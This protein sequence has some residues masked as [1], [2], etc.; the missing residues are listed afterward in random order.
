MKGIRRHHDRLRRELRLN[1]DPAKQNADTTIEHL[2]T[3]HKEITKLSDYLNDTIDKSNARTL[4]DGTLLPEL[5]EL[6]KHRC[7]QFEGLSEKTAV[8]HMGTALQGDSQEAIETALHRLHLYNEKFSVSYKAVIQERNQEWSLALF[9]KR[10]LKCEVVYRYGDMSIDV[11][12]IAY[13]DGQIWTVMGNGAISTVKEHFDG[14]VTHIRHFC[15]HDAFR[16]YRI[17]KVVPFCQNRNIAIS[18]GKLLVINNDGFIMYVL[19]NHAYHDVCVYA[20]FVYGLIIKR[21]LFNS[22]IVKSHIK[23]YQ[24]QQQTWQCSRTISLD[25]EITSLS[26]HGT[27]ATFSLTTN[28]TKNDTTL[29][30]YDLVSDLK[31]VARKSIYPQRCVLG[32]TCG[33]V[34]YSTLCRSSEGGYGLN[35]LFRDGSDKEV[36][37]QDLPVFGETVHATVNEEGQL[38]VQSGKVL[39]RITQT[40][41]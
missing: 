15:V 35:V 13:I 40:K 31:S 8:P 28:Q 22:A 33:H 4:L 20:Q 41:N 1:T 21:N 19:D 3:E 12:D 16:T 2:D 14:T 5:M 7:A 30:Y 25:G 29:Y 6:T 9:L 27:K 18:E 34:L 32:D 36:K 11:R 17:T 26:I 23:I 37:A 24:F 39:Y 38:L 10:N